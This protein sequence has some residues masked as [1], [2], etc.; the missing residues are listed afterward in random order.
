MDLAVALAVSLPPWSHLIVSGCPGRF[1][2]L[3]VAMR[4]FEAQQLPRVSRLDGEAAASISPRS[5]ID[6][7]KIPLH[8]GLV[9][10]VVQNV[11]QMRLLEL[12]VPYSLGFDDETV[13][14]FYRVKQCSCRSAAPLS[15]TAST[16][17][18]IDSKY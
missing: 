18:I 15:L 3:S 12:R 11:V 6:Y 16:G 4:K 17:A 5:I 1:C 10:T 8:I 7:P 2:H 9:C 13:I 14:E